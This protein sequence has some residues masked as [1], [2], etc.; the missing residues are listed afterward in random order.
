MFEWIAN[1]LGT[2]LAVL[3]LIIIIAAII[4]KM[5]KDKKQ[6]KSGCGCGFESCAMHGQCHKK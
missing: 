5:V 1:N 6:G 2:I 3:A 4:I